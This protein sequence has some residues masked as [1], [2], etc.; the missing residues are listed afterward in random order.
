MPV[1]HGIT[2]EF[3]SVAIMS[4]CC[5]YIT[6]VANV[7]QCCISATVLQ[8]KHCGNSATLWYFCHP[9]GTR[10]NFQYIYIPSGPHGKQFGPKSIDKYSIPNKIFALKKGL[11]II[12][13]RKLIIGVDI[14]KKV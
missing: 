1:F 7:S 12:N 14:P 5:N 10:W 6:G 3:L 4:Q 8:L 9:G 2:K 13:K 11:I